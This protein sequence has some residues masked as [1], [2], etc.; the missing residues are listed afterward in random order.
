MC[1]KIGGEGHEGGLGILEVLP[2]CAEH[3]VGCLWVFQMAYGFWGTQ[4]AGAP[5]RPFF[6]H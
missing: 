4:A 5:Y 2:G 6:L 3:L 1:M